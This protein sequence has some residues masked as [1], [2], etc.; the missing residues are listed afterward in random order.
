MG[1]WNIADHHH[2]ENVGPNVGRMHYTPI[3]ALTITHLI[4][5][6]HQANVGH[7]MPY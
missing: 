2:T 7:M 3:H 6:K 5:H 1:P 4:S